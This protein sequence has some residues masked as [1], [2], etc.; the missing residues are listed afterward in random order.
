[1]IRPKQKVKGGNLEAVRIASQ[2][3][4]ETAYVYKTQDKTAEE[5]TTE[6]EDQRQTWSSPFVSAIQTTGDK[7]CRQAADQVE[8]RSGWSNVDFDAVKGEEVST[9]E[10][11]KEKHE[12]SFHYHESGELYAEDVDQHMAVFMKS[13]L[14]QLKITID[15]IQVDQERRWPKVKKAC[16]NWFERIDICLLAKEMPYL[17]QRVELCVTSMSATQTPSLNE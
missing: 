4:G 1:M 8:N 6:S 13:F 11:K 5:G 17:R 9:E 12:T 10:T 2:S 14:P 15:E 7:K 16:G 3:E